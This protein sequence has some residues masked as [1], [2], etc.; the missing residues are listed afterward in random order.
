MRQS[1]VFV[2]FRA[3]ALVTLAL[4][5]GC[6]QAP[7]PPPATPLMADRVV[8]QKSRRALDLLRDGKVFATYPV[9]LG[10][11]PFGP[12]QQEGDGLTTEDRKSTRLNSSHGYIS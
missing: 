11:Q 9:A 10:R 4:V 6:A 8:V 5:G 2:V 3:F 7:P 12:K 1:L